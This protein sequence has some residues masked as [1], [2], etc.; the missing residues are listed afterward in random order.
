MTKTL[1]RTLLNAS[2]LL[3]AGTVS[4]TAQTITDSPHDL[5]T[6]NANSTPSTSGTDEL[7]VFCHTPHFTADP[8]AVPVALWNRSNPVSTTFTMYNSPTLDMTVAADPQGVSLAC[9]SC[10]DGATAL[11]S[12]LNEPQVFT[13]GTAVM[14]NP[15]GKDGLANDHPV[16]ITY[17]TGADP[18]FADVVAGK[19]AGVLPLFRA[20]GVTTGDGTQVECA[21]CHSSHDWTANGNFLR[22]SNAASNLCLTCHIK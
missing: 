3:L 2:L 4:V 16:S 18:G 17:D 21:S 13:A 8:S 22:V 14:T 9:L 7:C 11:D 6:G 20:P 10:H 12:I 1:S 15:V 5:S 19:I